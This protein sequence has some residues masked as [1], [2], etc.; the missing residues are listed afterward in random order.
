MLS[1]PIAA[2]AC[3]YL[4]ADKKI[5]YIYR[6]I[7]DAA[8]VFIAARYRALERTETTKPIAK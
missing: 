4:G 1:N 2:L 7:V 3:G 6:T 5:L 8:T